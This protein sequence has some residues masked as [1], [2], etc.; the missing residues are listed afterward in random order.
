MLFFRQR[1]NPWSWRVRIICYALQLLQALIISFNNKHT[2]FLPLSSL[3]YMW[4]M[5]KLYNFM[6]CCGIFLCAE[7][8]P[9]TLP[10]FCLYILFFV[11][12]ILWLMFVVFVFT[13]NSRTKFYF[14]HKNVATSPNN[15]NTH[16]IEV[17]I[18]NWLTIP[19]THKYNK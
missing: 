12:F 14:L 2:R 16:S 9:T 3:H 17:F 1:C 18:L 4:E 11:F 13:H 15:N 10:Q 7:F 8:T 5:H 19:H 6:L